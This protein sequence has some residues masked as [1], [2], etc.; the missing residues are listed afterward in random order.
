VCLVSREL[1]PFAGGGIG[2]YT[3]ALAGVLADAGADVTVI[4]RAAHRAEHERLV[5]EGHPLPNVRWLW[6]PDPDGAHEHAFVGYHHAWSGLVYEAVREAYGSRG[7]DVLEFP[8]YHGEAFVTLQAKRTGDR[9]LRDTTIA[10]RAHCSWEM[11]TRLNGYLGTDDESRALVAL[12]RWSLAN[13]DCLLYAGGDIAGTYGRVYGDRLAPA[14][15]IRHPLALPPVNPPDSEYECPWPVRFLYLGRLERRKGAHR[16]LEAALANPSDA[17]SL[18]Y[19]GGDTQSGVL[20]TSLTGQ[21]ELMAAGDPRVRFQPPV[22][23]SLVPDLIRMHDIL[24]MPSIWECWPYVVLEAL[25]LGRPALATPTG[26]LVELVQPGISGWRS[27]DTS[28]EALSEAMGELIADPTQ[29]T[30]LV[31]TGKPERHAQ[32]LTEPEG[33]A[34][35]YRRLA[36]EPL[37]KPPKVISRA[38]SLVSVIVTYHRLHRFIRDAVA[39]I[40]AQSWPR[41]E[42]VVVD[43]GSLGPEDQVLDT[44]AAGDIPVRVVTQPN[45]G[46]GAARNL[47]ISVARG[48]YVFPLD[49][50]N[51]AEPEFVERAVRVLDADPAIAYVTA[52]SRFVDEDNEPLLPDSVAGYSPLGNEVALVEELNVAGDAA[53]VLPRRLFEIGYSYSEDVAI[54]EDWMLYRSLRRDGRYGVVIPERLMRYR[55]RADSMYQ[56]GG[57]H[58]IDRVR[59]EIATQLELDQIRWVAT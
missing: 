18:T 30:E 56:D 12:E 5:A 57:Y 20:G 21:L 14:A 43:D 52:W 7:P 11:C 42:I 16:I 40:R 10:V 38:P 33:I 59:G 23:R 13:A 49:A 58:L 39:S 1:A 26:G 9:M 19:L 54:C 15:R 35:S 36:E 46:L 32:E 50:D 34:R 28:V 37:A 17:W 44:L 8:D 25:A 4:S 2:V 48:R 51:M 31:R 47:G 24:V 3:T 53:A 6:V 55:V 41:I 45:G 27:R 29:V 22:P